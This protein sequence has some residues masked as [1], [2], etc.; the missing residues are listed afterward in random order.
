V[1]D[2]VLDHPLPRNDSGGRTVRGYLV[3]L[4][5]RLWERGE[6]FSGKHP[7]GNSGWEDELVA[8]LVASGAARDE[9]HASDLVAEAI[10][11]L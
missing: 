6:S 3:E 7:F 4:L 1:T 11:R 8:P 2:P 5:A 9:D 10:R